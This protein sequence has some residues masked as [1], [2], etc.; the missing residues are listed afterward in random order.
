MVF[1]REKQLKQGLD[2]KLRHAKQLAKNQD[3]EYKIRYPSEA[4]EAS[5]GQYT[6]LTKRVKTEFKENVD[7]ILQYR[8]THWK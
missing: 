4:R 6:L 1:S 3:P 8:E 2:M 5:Q 7:K